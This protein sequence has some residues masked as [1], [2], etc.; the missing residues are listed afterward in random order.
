MATVQELTSVGKEMGLTG[1]ALLTF[2][3]EQQAMAREE[4]AAQRT[5]EKDIQKLN[6]EADI[7]VR[8]ADLQ[9]QKLRMEA[10]EREKER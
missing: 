6:S 10:E 7:S 1:E 8:Q 4:R 9:E 2:V 3:K 5:L